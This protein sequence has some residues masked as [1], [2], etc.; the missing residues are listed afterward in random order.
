MRR[1]ALAWRSLVITA[2]VVVG[3]AQALVGAAIVAVRRGRPAAKRHLARR[4]TTTVMRLG[5][6]FVKA[7][8]ILGTRRDVLPPLLC[9]EL[10]ALRDDVAALGPA[11]SRAALAAVYGPDVAAVFAEVDYTAVAGG[12]VACVYRATLP[13]GAD[14]AVKL[15]RPGIRPLMEADLALIRRGA[16]MVARLSAFRGVPVRELVDNLCDAVLGQLDFARE[17]ASLERMRANLTV[18]SRVRVPRVR[19]DA[20]R[21]E[22]I[23]MEFVSDLDIHTSDRCTLVARRSFAKSTL[24]VMYQMLFIDGFVHCDM[25]PGNLYFLTTGQTVVLDA[26]F[27]TQ[28]TDKM[29]RL[30]ADFFLNFAVGRGS[31]CAELVLESALGIRD[32]GDPA[33]FKVDMAELVVRNYG[34]PAK[35]FSLMAFATEMF[36]LQRRYGIAAAPEL[37]FPLLALLVIEGTVRDL[38]P[39]IDFQEEAKPTLNRAVFGVGSTAS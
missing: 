26:G 30:F 29:R 2:R 13:D 31:R 5:P 39:D 34:L 3:V 20:S 21:P 16:A 14:V 17:A 27:S 25:H 9:D 8:Q 1:S 37:V 33:A 36:E 38:D 35:D 18:L 19:F 15:Q 11:R 28:L 4:V 32:D 7:G 22:C 10:S 6:T 24:D 12:S 23:V